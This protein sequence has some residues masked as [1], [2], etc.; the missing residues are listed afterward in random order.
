[1]CVIACWISA[2]L[3]CQ[4]VC[5]CPEY[6]CICTSVN[7]YSAYNLGFHVTQAF[8]VSSQRLQR[9]TSLIFPT[10]VLACR[11]C[12]CFA[13][14]LLTSNLLYHHRLRDRTTVSVLPAAKIILHNYQSPWSIT[15]SLLLLSC[16]TNYSSNTS[17]HPSNHLSSTHPI[18]CAWPYMS[19]RPTRP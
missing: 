10:Y 7:Q 19:K 2:N 17:V 15:P 14:Q 6:Q 11:N 5:L 8:Y 13:C 1:M 4:S 9:I 16:G 12:M 18:I 3:H